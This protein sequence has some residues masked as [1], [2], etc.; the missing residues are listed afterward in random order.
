LLKGSGEALIMA[1]VPAL[2]KCVPAA[3]VP[4]MMRH[5]RLPFDA[6]AAEDHGGQRRPAGMR[7]KVCTVSHTESSSGILSAKNSMN[8]IRPAAPK[9]Q[10]C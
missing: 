7:M 9:T 8:S 10:G 6:L 2:V 3:S 1:R 4:P 5:R